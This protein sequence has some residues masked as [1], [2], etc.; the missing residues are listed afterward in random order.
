ML[1]GSVLAPTPLPN[2]TPRLTGGDGRLVG[3]AMAQVSATYTVDDLDWARDALGT[4]HIEID[5]DGQ[6]VVSPATDAHEWVIRALTGI[7]IRGHAGEVL[8]AGW[9]WRPRGGSGRVNVPDLMVVAP[10]SVRFGPDD[11]DWNPLPLLVVEV[12]SRSTRRNDRNPGPG[13]KMDEYRVGGAGCYLL[14]DLPAMVNVAEP[15]VELL[16]LTK[17]QWATSGPQPQVTLPESLGSVT[18]VAAELVFAG[19][20][21]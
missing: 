1:H 18:V 3:V 15:T 10:G 14:V 5:E 13:G 20:V 6:L 19:R 2:T 4:I 12:A 17:G 9:S 8:S 11:L 16:T 21:G 7:L